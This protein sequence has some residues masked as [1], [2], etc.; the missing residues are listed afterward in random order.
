LNLNPL[1][2]IIVFDLKGFILTG[3]ILDFDL[4]HENSQRY[5][6]IENNYLAKMSAS[7]SFAG[8]CFALLRALP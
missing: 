7:V 3:L 8:T 4:V 2:L 6:V 1:D 5:V